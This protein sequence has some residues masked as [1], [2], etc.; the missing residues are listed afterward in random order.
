[1]A[2]HVFLAFVEED[3]DLVWMFR[4]HATNK[5]TDLEFGD[6]SVKVPYSSAD[7]ANIRTKSREK[8]GLASVTICLIGATTHKSELG[9][10]GDRN[11]RGRG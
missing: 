3:L 11:Q 1:M 2:K 9:R 8:I 6:Y 10:L 5:K 4:G 7:A